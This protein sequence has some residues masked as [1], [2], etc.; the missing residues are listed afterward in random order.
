VKADPAANE[1]NVLGA[2]LELGDAR[3]LHGS[4]TG[5]R[6][7]RQKQ[8]FLVPANKATRFRR[9]VSRC[10]LGEDVTNASRVPRCISFRQR[11]D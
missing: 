11:K 1:L 2:G 6:G 3:G 10:W 7:T 9:T 4:H 5:F 8:A